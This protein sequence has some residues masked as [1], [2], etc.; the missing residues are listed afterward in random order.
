MPTSLIY[1][2]LIVV[3]IRLMYIT[4][5]LMYMTTRLIVMY[6]SLVEQRFW[7]QKLDLEGGNPSR[8][9]FL[10]AVVMHADTVRY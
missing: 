5:R 1:T 8:S 2:S 3:T 4:T 10:V 9:R 6:I 7:A